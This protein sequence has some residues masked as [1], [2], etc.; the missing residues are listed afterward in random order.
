[1]SRVQSMDPRPRDWRL[2]SYLPFLVERGVLI[3]SV[4]L[5]LWSTI[6]NTITA[7]VL[8]NKNTRDKTKTVPFPVRNGR[9]AMDRQPKADRQVSTG[10]TGKQGPPSH[11]VFCLTSSH[12]A[13]G[14]RCDGSGTATAA[15]AA[16]ARRTAIVS[17]SAGRLL[18]VRSFVFTRTPH[19]DAILSMVAVWRVVCGM[20]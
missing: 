10:T 2:S 12:L 1:M 18:S 15:A 5:F 4:V 3:V 20:W 6:I 11:L 14:G 7:I 9:A 19:V 16:Q 8:R 17:R 13:S